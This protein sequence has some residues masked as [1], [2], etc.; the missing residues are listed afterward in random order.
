[1]PKTPDRD[2]GDAIEGDEVDSTILR[3]QTGDPTIEGQIQNNNGSLKA[4]DSV[5]VFDL[6]SGAGLSEAAHKILR[7][8]I[9]FI[10]DG[11][12][13][14]FVSG[15]FKEILPSAAIFP[16]SIIWWESAAKN[17][18]IVEKTI[19]Y[20]GVT[21]TT[22]VWK[23]YDTDGSTVLETLTDAISYSGVFETTRTRTI[24]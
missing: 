6:R 17:D 23:I 10:D 14:G 7:Q 12:A 20:S 8:A 1:M 24:A 11:P 9:H 18:K 4:K 5:G 3:N 2:Y 19:T 16:T 13:G 15:A 22:V 21:A